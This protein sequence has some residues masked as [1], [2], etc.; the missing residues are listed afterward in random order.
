M[1][2]KILCLIC[3]TAMVFTTFFAVS[4]IK[5]GD[6]SS[7]SSDSGAT[8]IEEIILDE[9]S[10]LITLGET[11]SLHATDGENTLL[12]KWSSS[13]ENV[14]S[15][16]EWGLLTANKVGSATVAAEYGGKKASCSVTVS[17]GGYLPSLEIA[18]DDEVQVDL[19]HS[20][21]ISGKVLFNGK[22]Y[23]DAKINYDLTD[24]T[25]GKVVNGVFKPAKAG[26]TTVTVTAEWRDV[27]SD[28]LTREIQ[29]NVIHNVNFYADGK[30]VPNEVELYTIKNFEGET[31]ETE[32]KLN[33][34]VDIDGVEKT[35]SVGIENDEIVE[36]DPTTGIL[37][38]KK[39][40]ATTI[41]LYCNNGET[42]FSK[43]IEI[44]VILPIAEYGE[45]ITDFSA[46]NGEI[47]YNESNLLTELF[48][49]GI[50]YA[51]QD[52][53][54]LDVSGAGKILGVQTDKSGISR[55]S[56][57]VYGENYGY[58]FNLE[59]CALV[60][61]TAEDLLDFRLTADKK[62][63]EGYV[64]MKNDVDMSV[65]DFNG[66]GKTATTGNTAMFDTF[67]PYYSSAGV[68]GSTDMLTDIESSKAVAGFTGIFEGNGY[69][70][71][72]F[73]AGNSYGFFGTIS[74]ATV[75]NVA[76]TD[77]DL[78]PAYSVGIV[79]AKYAANV[80]MQNVY[81]SIKTGDFSDDNYIRTKNC[82]LFAGADSTD[83]S[84]ENCIIETDATY[85]KDA[86]P[87]WGGA[88]VGI[89]GSAATTN[90][91]VDYPTYPGYMA[92]F[93]IKGLYFIAPTA[94]NGRV[95]P[96]IQYNGM[97]VYASNDFVD[98][99]ERSTMRLDDVTRNPV[100]DDSGNQKIYHWANAYRYDGYAQ[101]LES[102]IT[103]V[104]NWNITADGVIWAG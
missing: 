99:A 102:G 97:T 42:R 22:Y 61:K 35:S 96:L 58:K 57:T 37:T 62:T 24:K 84:F 30:P 40:G 93:S 66:D 5:N 72:N 80:K 68:L 7:D 78:Y 60:I 89:F 64:V 65:L 15:V 85:E 53:R 56:V 16:N 50:Y 43:T 55:F 98:F 12:C 29:I 88:S 34:S 28:F 82:M 39:S 103:K 31:Y 101:M 19:A 70:I 52:G 23:S 36:Y 9:K 92:K 94:A 27:E 49:D 71:K 47:R 87:G 59:G 38:A 104:G 21:D 10:V 11:H 41:E 25:I 73:H 6:N 45:V 20:A 26:S 18:C 46:L 100:A 75:R 86:L 4:C 44:N 90:Y 48:A 1:K 91:Y 54:A 14:V 3:L 67:Y 33:P 69:K 74:A 83:K 81:L 2:R 77:V 51:E 76:F 95:M 63:I 79:F 8:T 13:N 17:L 32:W